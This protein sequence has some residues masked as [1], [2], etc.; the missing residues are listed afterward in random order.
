MALD[1]GTLDL[2]IVGLA[3]SALLALGLV[4]GAA[5]SRRAGHAKAGEM[6]PE[7][8]KLLWLRLDHLATESEHIAREV[9]RLQQVPA[10]TSGVEQQLGRVLDHLGQ[11]RTALSDEQ[12]RHPAEEQA[13]RTLRKLESVLIN[14]GQRG[15]LGEHIVRQIFAGL[16]AEWWTEN[17]QVRNQ[18]VEFALRLP[19]DTYLPVDSKFPA[20]QA[21][22]DAAQLPPED[23]RRGEI[24]SRLRSAVQAR[25]KDIGKYTDAD[26]TAGFGVLAL[27]DGAYRAALPL[28][29]NAYTMHRAILVPYSLLGPYLLTVYQYHLR[30]GRNPD[31][32]RLSRALD[33]LRRHLDGAET[34]VQQL[35]GSLGLLEGTQRRL[36]GELAEVRAALVALDR[37]RDAEEV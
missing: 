10:Q 8:A 11:L 31:Q 36:R 34:Q 37:P 2:L 32:Q 15:A 20:P 33:A 22:L 17:F 19:D 5:L 1:A 7:S 4:V 6:I 23:P 14:S 9:A 18:V 16:P 3:A 25:L 26:R 12:A 21:A 28:I 24:D 35:G 30:A 27:P 29:A 13:W